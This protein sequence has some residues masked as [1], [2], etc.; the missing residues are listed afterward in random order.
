MDLSRPGLKKLHTQLGASFGAPLIVY[1]VGLVAAS[2]SDI[3]LARSSGASVGATH[4][5][6]EASGLGRVTFPTQLLQHRAQR[7]ALGPLDGRG[8]NPRKTMLTISFLLAV[9]LYSVCWANEWI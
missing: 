3:P 2:V 4:G 5:R 7:W 9:A 6:T 8:P 1:P